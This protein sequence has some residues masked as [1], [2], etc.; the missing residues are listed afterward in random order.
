MRINLL[1]PSD[2]PP[3]RAFMLQA[4]E[5]AADAFTS[6]A[7]ERAAEPDSWWI[8]RIA[9]PQGMS[10]A[11]GAFEGSEL[12]GTVALEFSAKPKTKHKAL[13]IGMYVEP[14]RR[15]TGVGKALLD[16]ALQYAAARAGTRVVTL[17]VTQGNEPAIG[18]YENA[19]FKVFGIEPMA[20]LTSTGYKA[21]VH[22]WR[23]IE[24]DFTASIA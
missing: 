21:K 5:Q 18:L 9:D 12:V 10:V 1:T 20:I 13:L 4:Y 14:S 16:F 7:A 2:V 23:N 11:L 8:Q 17:T 6:T 19:G 22:M 15:G 24:S 3:Y